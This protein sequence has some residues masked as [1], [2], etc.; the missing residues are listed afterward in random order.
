MAEAGIREHKRGAGT[1][2]GFDARD[3]RFVVPGRTA[4]VFV[5]EK[6]E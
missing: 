2:Q 5:I 1:D 4:V 3:G 6:G